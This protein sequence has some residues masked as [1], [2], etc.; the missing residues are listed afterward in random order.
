MG[1]KAGRRGR[2][3]ERPGL[4][5]PVPAVFNEGCSQ[6]TRFLAFWPF[7]NQRIPPGTCSRMSRKSLVFQAT[8]SARRS[9]R[10]TAGRLLLPLPS[11]SLF[12]PHCFQLKT[13]SK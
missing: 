5:S 2:K 10:D 7:P 9:G 8:A 11:F 12:S 4:F 6:G 1:G 3:A 13:N